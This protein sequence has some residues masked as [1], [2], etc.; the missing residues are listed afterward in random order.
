METPATDVSPW[1]LIADWPSRRWI[2]SIPGRHHDLPKGVRLG[3]ASESAMVLICTLPRDRFDAEIGPTGADPVREI[4]FE[5]TYAQINLALHQIRAPGARPDGLIESLVRYASQQANR[6]REWPEAHWG[7][8]CA[9]T[10]ALASWQSGFSLDYPGDYVIVHACGI[11]IDRIQ[12][13]RVDDLSEYELGRDPLEI[14]AMHWE[15]WPSRPE[16]GYDDLAKTLVTA[17]P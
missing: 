4:A 1:G 7:T 16:L 5:T 17:G 2:E 10:A 8:E 11:G 15:L 9:R 3:H 6:Y 14:G 12:L 13:Q